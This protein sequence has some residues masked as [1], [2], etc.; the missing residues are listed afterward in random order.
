MTNHSN[1]LQ[2]PR[3][4]W[5]AQL[6]LGFAKKGARTALVH[7][8]H[9]GPLTV[10]KAL[11]PEGESVCHAVVI[12]PPGGVAG[13]DFLT[14]KIE[15][16]A[17]ASAVVTTPAATKWYKACTSVAQ[18]RIEICVAEHATLDWLPQENIFFNDAHVR[19]VLNLRLA[20]GA[21]VIGWDAGVLGR[22]LSGEEWLDGFLSFTNKAYDWRDAPIW[23]DRM[24]LSATSP[25][26]QAPHGL[27]GLNVFGTLWAIGP[28]TETAELE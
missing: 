27:G 12:H 28:G 23:T 26:R 17:G 25:L 22:R 2:V 10:Q 13:G 9:Q 11:Y 6:E 21:S 20:A 15:V 18:Q 24:L 16:A 3:P 5:F 4:E 19:S 7:S 1:Q 8:R 14:I